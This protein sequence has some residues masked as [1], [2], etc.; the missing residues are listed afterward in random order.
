MSVASELI[1]LNAYRALGIPGVRYIKPELLFRHLPE[2]RQARWVLFPEYW[3]V[4]TLTY[5]LKKRLF[6]NPATYHLGHDKIE[7]TRAFLSVAPAHVPETRILPST[8]WDGD[9]VH[10]LGLPLVA[11]EP[12]SSMGIGVHLIK[13]RRELREFAAKHDTLYLQE[14]LPID[15]DLRV[16]Y[17]GR[18]VIAAYWRIGAEGSF[19]NNVARGGSVSFDD[20]PQAALELVDQVAT[21]LEVNHAGFDIA[22]V[23]GHYYLLEFNTLF[24]NEALNSRGISVAQHIWHYLCEQDE[25]PPLS[26]Q[27][28]PLLKS[29]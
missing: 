8:E 16:V 17:V 26:P 13:T 14:Y 21:E 7:M 20:I 6:P 23:G 19:H 15:R 10:E 11:K 4:N 24:G 12:R 29:A 27:D 9:A 28:P 5:A 3:Q 18:K 25:T 2:I 1:T 22:E